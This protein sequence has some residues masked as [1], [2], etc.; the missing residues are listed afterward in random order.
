[1]CNRTTP[2]KL[3]GL[4]VFSKL[5]FSLATQ[6]YIVVAGSKL[7]CLQ[8]APAC[9]HWGNLVN[10]PGEEAVGNN[11]LPSSLAVYG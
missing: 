3:P 9:S 11:V 1:M 4:K 8:T 5:T 6:D 7:G 10:W 2:L